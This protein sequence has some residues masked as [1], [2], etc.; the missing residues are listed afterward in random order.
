MI[1]VRLNEIIGH[2]YKLKYFNN[3]FAIL[4]TEIN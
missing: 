3:S 4:Y 1:I 2:L